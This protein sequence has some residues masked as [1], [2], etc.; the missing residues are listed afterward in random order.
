[1]TERDLNQPPPRVAQAS[2]DSPT[3]AWTPPRNDLVEDDSALTPAEP[4]RTGQRGRGSRVR[5]GIALLV[6]ALVVAVGAAAVILLTGQSAPST[7]VGYAPSE[8]VAYGE[9][10]LDFPGDQKQQLGQFL[11]KFPGFADQ[12]TLDLKIDDVL[13]RVVRAATKDKQD[14]TT[15]IKPW[16]GGELGFAVGGLPAAG[17]AQ[18][19]R[20]LVMLSVTDASRAKAWFDE[21]TADVAKSTSSYN[22]V[23]LTVAG[24]GKQGAMAIHGGRVML[25]GDEQSVKAA[26]DTGGRSGIDT[27]G[28]LADALAS[29]QGDSLGYAFFDLERYAAWLEEAARSVPVTSRIPLDDLR[30][31]LPK[32]MLMR[33]QAR[34]DALAFETVM[35]HT[36][37]ISA[38]GENR[39]GVLAQHVPPS[40]I[41]L[42]DGHEAG[43]TI[44]QAIDKARANPA[45]AEGIRQLDQVAS[46]VGGV[47]GL[48]GWI[49]DAGLAIARDGDAVTGGLVFTP[50]DRAEAER[51]LTTLRSF[52]QLGGSSMGITVRDEDYKGTKI[53]IIDAGDFRD[54]A[55]LAGGATALPPGTELPEGRLEI[56]YVSTDDIVAVGIGTGFIHSVI[57]AGGGDSLADDGRYK[58]LLDKAGASNTGSAWLDVA[59]VRELVERLGPT[60]PEG[61]AAYERDV[62]PYLLP[63]DAVVQTMTRDGDLDRTT[64]TLTVK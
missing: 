57:D 64:T 40:T 33:A 6:T 35:P 8:S 46:L 20:G 4:V 34:G 32:W 17:Q 62:K 41:V 10:R 44:R 9:I 55:A 50:T 15:R 1:M 53:G 60:D 54:L 25:V 36:T 23:D 52:A 47:D 14:W 28:G 11:S 29:V 3:V 5:W 21:V 38:A 16:F 58:A 61:F 13:D 45:N 19:T 42:L 49:G 37:A 24:D 18:E 12:S 31:M 30:E 27:E 26:I 39:V 43:K 2:S 7:I 56:A 22:G 51:L 63:I 48:I 59:A